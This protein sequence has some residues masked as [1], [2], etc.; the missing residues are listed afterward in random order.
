MPPLNKFD[1]YDACMEVHQ[2]K[3]K[4][5][6]V[7]TAIKPDLSSEL[8]NFISEFSS[9]KKQHFRHDKLTR[10]ICVNSCQ[11][12]LDNLEALAAGEADSFYLPPFELDYKVS[13]L[14]YRNPRQKSTTGLSHSD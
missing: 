6:Y 10:G 5:C 13:F 14:N 11:K 8:Y 4:Y 1:D 12:M 2:E 7:R 3:A 9:K